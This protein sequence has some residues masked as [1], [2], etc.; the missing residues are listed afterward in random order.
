MLRQ[1]PEE[2][3]VILTPKPGPQPKINGPRLFGAR[4][5]HPFV[6]RIPCTGTR[7]I[8]FAA[9]NLPGRI[10]TRSGHRH[11]HGESPRRRG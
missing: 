10:E 4:P 7:P 6:Y 1:L 8:T 9:D 11:H 2:P 3:K 5:G